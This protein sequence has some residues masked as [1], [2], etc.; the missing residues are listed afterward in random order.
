MA[1]SQAYLLL[2]LYLTLWKYTH[3]WGVLDSR[4]FSH[5]KISG[6]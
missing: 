6:G 3:F 2:I 4:P 1:L 5:I